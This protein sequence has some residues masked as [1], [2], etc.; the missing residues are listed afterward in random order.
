MYDR[1]RLSLALA[2]TICTV[3]L[4]GTPSRADASMFAIRS[5]D[6]RGNNELHPSWGRA[7]TLY[8]RLAP[9]DYRDGISRM[10]GGPSPRY[11]SNRVFND[12]GQNLFSENGVS[13]W[14]WVWGQF[15]DHDIGLRDRKSTRLNSSHVKISYAVFCL[16]KKRITVSDR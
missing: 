5:L 4:A 1:R 14:G 2:L 12:G 11:V 15:V 13:Q 8:L 16:K 9:P 10:E 3:V 6:G 7:N